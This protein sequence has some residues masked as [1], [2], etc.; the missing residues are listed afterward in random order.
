MATEFESLVAAFHRLWPSAE[1]AGQPAVVTQDAVLTYGALAQR[2]GGLAGGLRAAGIREGDR[3]AIAMPR[4]MDLVCA[5][6]ATLAAGACPC[7][8]EP[9]LGAEETARR[10]QVTGMAWLLH[11]RTQDGDTA[12]P[13]LAAVKRL[14]FEDLPLDAPPYWASALQPHD[15]AY[16]LFTSGSSGS[17]KGVLHSHLGL[18]TNA[19]G[20]LQHTQLSAQDRL[21]HTMPLHHTN[22][23]NNQLLAPLLAGAQVVLAERFKA[24]DMPALMQRYRPTIITGVPTMYSRMLA[25]D[26]PAASLADLR[27]ARCGSAPIT[28]ELHRQVEEKLGVALV[29][30]YGLSEATCTSTMNPPHARRLGSVGTVLAGQQVFLADRNGRAIEAP[31]QEGEICIGGP[32]LMLGYLEDPAAGVPASPGPVLRTGDLGRFDAQGFLYIT[33]RI[34]DVILRGGENLSPHLIEGVLAKV[35][36]VRA[37]CVVGRPDA[38]LG[39]VPCAFVVRTAD[40]SGSGLTEPQLAAAV[41]GELSRIHVPV[42]CYYL[43]A[44]PENSV[45]KVD[46]K[47]LKAALA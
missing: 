23:V 6:L 26:F 15:G 34:K 13:A 24:Q 28:Q 29:V 21:L 14:A 18:R 43:D 3:V 36:G 38:D 16:L 8:L 46:R 17:P 2:V 11:D 37:C 19:D 10:L 45:G 30:S 20:I 35:P 42:A 7:V 12:L 5:L 31:L 44:L 40:A 27:M 39:E 47:R 32:A 4:S 25:F 33:G 22:G 9:D 41:H 1:R